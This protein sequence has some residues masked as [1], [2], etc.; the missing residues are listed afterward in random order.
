VSGAY[1]V[2]IVGGVANAIGEPQP[3]A[4]IFDFHKVSV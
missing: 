2:I 3:S 4:S 1:D